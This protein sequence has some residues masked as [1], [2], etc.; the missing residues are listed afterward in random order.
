MALSSYE[1]WTHVY[2]KVELTLLKPLDIR[3]TIS[4]RVEAVHCLC[5]GRQR[6][7]V[8]VRRMIVPRIQ[9]KRSH[10]SSLHQEALFSF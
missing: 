7:K 5:A 10:S 9:G 1:R 6:S 2:V 3:A 8:H 4:L